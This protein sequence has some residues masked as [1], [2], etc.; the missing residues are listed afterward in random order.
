MAH[1]YLQA[2]ND[3]NTIGSWH[4]EGSSPVIKVHIEGKGA[5][6][7][8][9]VKIPAYTGFSI[10]LVETNGRDRYQSGQ[11][12]I[13]R[14][15]FTACSAEEATALDNQPVVA[16]EQHWVGNKDVGFG[17]NNNKELLLRGP[18][19]ERQEQDAVGKWITRRFLKVRVNGV[20][21]SIELLDPDN[22]R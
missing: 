17:Y 12:F 20:P 6:T 4:S 1:I 21:R 2:R 5:H 22:P 11:C 8:L 15:S 3:D 16:F 9:Y 19:F 14:K 10:A 7:K 13:F 18:F